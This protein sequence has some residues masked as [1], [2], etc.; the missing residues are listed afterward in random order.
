M[1][2]Y[3]WKDWYLD[4]HGYVLGTPEAE[5]AWK[6]KVEMMERPIKAPMAFVQRDICYDSP[7]DGRHITSMA[8]RKEDLARSGCIEYDPGMKQDAE[9]RAK[10]AEAATERAV[11]ETVEREFATMPSRKKEK[12]AA[13]IEGGLEPMVE[14]RSV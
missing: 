4:F 7:I 13:E 3:E 11:D 6:R 12:L 5:E 14:R 8:A 1:S 9:R 2:D 10:E